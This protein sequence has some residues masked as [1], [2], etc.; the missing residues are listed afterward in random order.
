MVFGYWDHLGAASSMQKPSFGGVDFGPD[1]AIDVNDLH[2]RWFDRWLKE[3]EPADEFPVARVFFTGINTWR[4]CESW[5]PP[6]IDMLWYLHSDGSAN[7]KDGNGTLSGS[8]PKVEPPDGFCYDPMDPVIDVPDLDRY[9]KLDP[10]NP[11]EPPLVRDFV[12]SRSDVLVYTSDP[13]EEP[14]RVAGEPRVVLYGG[15]DSP[16]TDWHAWITDVA[17]DGTSV[18]LVRGQIGARF[19]D[20]LAEEDLMTRGEVYRFEFELLSLAHVFRAGHRI[21]FVLASSDFPTYARN[22]NTGHPIG[23]DDKVR[24]ATNF[25]RHEQ[26]YPTHVVLPV[27]TES[28]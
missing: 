3:V 2:H 14:L 28:K 18:T 5:P 24:V 26:E 9:G 27:V 17:P 13:I 16:D 21:R 12:E 20:G 22:Q 4:D 25:I 8:L 15:S 1:S 23:L 7:S 19:R 10:T 6:M 11:L